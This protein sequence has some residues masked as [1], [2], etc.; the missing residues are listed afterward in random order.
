MSEHCNDLTEQ[1]KNVINNRY[2]QLGE[3]EQVI[4]DKKI[5][6]RGEL[7]A[8]YE[9]FAEKYPKTWVS[10]IDDKIMIGHLRQQIDSYVTMFKKSNGRTYKER[11]FNA[12]LQ[13]GNKLAEEYLYPTYGKPSKEALEKALV[14]TKAK[15]EKQES[16]NYKNNK[17]MKLDFDK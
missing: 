4:N 12:D 9:T 3:I 8:K 14:E 2:K 6:T 17:T 7:E 10:I 15:I 16:E 1:Q 5:L 13:F 11:K